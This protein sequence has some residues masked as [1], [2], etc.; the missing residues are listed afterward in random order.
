MKRSLE[1]FPISPVLILSGLGAHSSATQQLFY[2]QQTTGNNDA[3]L[4]QTRT[5]AASKDTAIKLG[6][7]T[8][9]HFSAAD[10]GLFIG[11]DF[12]GGTTL[13]VLFAYV[14]Q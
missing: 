11:R 4:S 5:T 13:N 3:A 7:E 9:C 14:P 1:V 12:V 2:Y 10:Y 8:F 6:F